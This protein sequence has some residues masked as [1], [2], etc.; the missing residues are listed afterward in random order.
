MSLLLRAVSWSTTYVVLACLPLVVALVADPIPESRSFVLELSV[1]LGLVAFALFAMELALV[2]RLRAASEPFGTDALMWFHRQM[3]IAAA[4]FALAHPLLLGPRALSMWNPFAGP[5]AARYGAAALWSAVVLVGVSVLRKR[6]R[7]PYEPWKRSHQVLAI[8]VVAFMWLHAREVG[9][10]AGAP[11]VTGALTAYAALFVVLMLRYDVVRPLLLARRPWEVVE[12]RDE[13]ADTRTLVV[14][15]AGHAGI[16][17]A[18]GQFAWLLTGKR[19]LSSEQHPISISSS[20]EPNPD[21]RLELSIKALGDWSRD[22]VPRIAPGARV[23][24]DG[25]FG[26][27]S[28]DRV[29]G[30][31]GFVLIA[32]G[33][34]VTPMRS[35]LATMR[36]RGDSRP[37]VLLYAANHPRRTVFG[38]ELERLAGEM[39]LR[40][41]YVFEE[42]DADWAGERGRVTA[43]VLRRH[44]PG[45]LAGR[46]YFVCG[47][48]PMMDSVEGI[49]AELGVPAERLSTERFDMV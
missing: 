6:L 27:F 20:A 35:M 14:R 39:D 30:A 17:F 10:Y 38:R 12:N 29:A 5:A 22:V 31:R 11:L 21:G 47:P 26:A 40:V 7:I 46:H 28:I 2:S 48:P 49:L 24:L 34:G 18:P 45:G 42:P 3:G 41:V 9:R 16:A 4:L 36:D 8:A 13:G 32:G 19:P 15:P 23:W 43:D 37:V 1:A 44:V 25:P 33:I